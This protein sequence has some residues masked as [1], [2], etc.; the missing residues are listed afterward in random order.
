MEGGDREMGGAVSQLNQMLQSFRLPKKPLNIDEYGTFKEQNSAGAAWWIAQ[1]ERHDAVGLRGN[2]LM[3]WALHDLM[4]SLVS[5]PGAEDSKNFN[6]ESTGYFPN[7]EFQVYKYYAQ[8]MTGHR[9]ATTPSGDKKLD[10]YATVGED[11]ARCLVGVRLATGTWQMRIEGLSALGLPKSG[12]VNIK[13]WGFPFTG[14]HYGRV[15]GPKDEGIV[16]HKYDD[17]SVTFPVFQKDQNTAYAFEIH[18]T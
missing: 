16:G 11:A 1:L 15:D 13:T 18:R 7:G 17:N 2:W 5:K 12:T 4:A 6:K 8:S 10:V 9:V 14:G 3:G